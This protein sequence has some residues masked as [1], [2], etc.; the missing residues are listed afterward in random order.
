MAVS[1]SVVLLGTLAHGSTSALAAQTRKL[2]AS[3]GSLNEPNGIAVT[4]TT[5][6]VYVA[7]S[8][9]HRILKFDAFGNQLLGFGADVG[10]PGVD[11]CAAVCEPGTGGTAPGQ[12]T[13]ARFV[14][15]DNS[16]GA[17]SGD[18]YVADTGDNTVSKFD[19]AGN[20]IA[21]WGAGGQLNGSTT[22][23]GAFGAI[24]GIAVDPSTGE[25]LV[26]NTER[27]LFGF[28]QDGTFESEA[29]GGEADVRA[30]GLGIDSEG[31]RLRVTGAGA[32]EKFSAA[33]A[34]LGAVTLE[35]FEFTAVTSAFAVDPNG[36]DLYV[37]TEGQTLDHYAFSGQEEVMQRDGSTCRI[38]ESGCA[39][40][41][42]TPIPF[43]G[44]G[45]G[46]NAESETLYVSNP[47]TGEIFVYTPATIPDVSK[48]AAS[49]VGPTSATLNGSVNPDGLALTGCRFE[50]GKTEAYGQSADCV[51]AAGSIPAD[52]SPHAVSAHVTGLEAGVTY[53]FRLVAED[54][55]GAN[56]SA[57][58][59][60]ATPPRPSIDDARAIELSPEAATLTTRIDPRG[61]DTHYH[62]EYGKTTEYGT[63]APVP[64]EDIGAGEG[65]VVRSQRVS[66]LQEGV[67]YHWRVV[68]ANENG[69]TI[70]TDH[71]F[72]YERAPASL[73]DGRAYEM[74]TPVDKNGALIGSLSLPEVARGG[75]R[76]MSKSIQCFAG[77]E[78]CNGQRKSGTG[79]PYEFER[80]GAGWVATAMSPSATMLPYSNL[81]A[82]EVNSGTA[83]F[84]APP[85]R[86]AADQLYTREPD[87][88]LV[89]VGP[90]TPPG[91]GALGPLGGFAGGMQQAYSPDLSHL[92]WEAP[93]GGFWPS[94]DGTKGPRSVY[95]YAAPGQSEPLLVGVTGGVG[96]NSLVSKCETQLGAATSQA[97]PGTMSADG[98]T[99]YVT[100]FGGEG[101][102]GTGEN[103]TKPVEADELLARVDGEGP[104]AHTV[105]V[106]AR[107][108]SDCSGT[109][110]SAPAAD[111]LFIGASADGAKAFFASTQQLTNQAGEDGQSGDSATDCAATTGRNGCNLYMYDFAN[112]A[113]ERLIDVSAGDTSGGGPRV[114]GVLAVSEDGSHVYFVAQGVLT[115]E[116]NA[117]GEEAQ[118]GADNLY[119]FERD[120]S[121]LTGRVKFIAGLPSSDAGEWTVEVGHPANVTP[122]GRYLVFV[123]H[124]DLTP[125]DT[126]RSGAWQVFRY[127]AHSGQLIRI[128]VGNDGFNN[129]GNG[130][131]P[132]PCNLDLCSEDAELAA[133]WTSSRNPTMSD[134][135]A[136]VFFESPVGLTPQALDDVRLTATS[137]PAYAENVYEWHEGHVYLI[138]DG[139][140]V[141][142]NAG[143]SPRC[144]LAGGTTEEGGSAVCLLGSDASGRDAFFTTTDP[145]TTEDTDTELDYY[146]A[147]ICTEAEP[148]VHSPAPRVSC[149]E[150]ECQGLPLPAP[151]PPVAA[152]VSFAG[153]GNA[154]APQASPSKGATKLVSHAVHGG[155]FA[156]VL[157][158]PSAG[159]VTIGGFGVASLKHGVARA[160]TYRFVVSLT[161][162]ERVTLRRHHRH[163]V[164]LKLKI[165]FAP[166][167]GAP[168]AIT[169]SMTARI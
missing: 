142:Q 157:R 85:E 82:Y 89:R 40:T 93:A 154:T 51:P 129:N 160:G 138:S 80:T 24:A 15:V 36:R 35:S 81:M 123:S 86:S 101:C 19:S 98:R 130:S 103:A 159:K 135:G 102:V 70:G 112:P 150:D 104:E 106:S 118:T 9:N 97:P 128:S 79:S 161:N 122:E 2:T 14:A 114:Q 52:S 165:G 27:Q 12:F 39:P 59:T 46:L 22:G 37:A 134:D 151:P 32:I 148:C 119:V 110:S 155:R 145:L 55:N 60:I 28:A 115:T 48:E 5:G 17:S 116:G 140:D 153:A 131:E 163:K 56:A 152:T 146:D 144:G 73:P 38:G 88:S 137:P 117:Q 34:D 83:F 125:D 107:S 41:D 53:H 77:A 65:D 69:T 111:A 132:S 84:S 1:A 99:V 43:V 127:D 78:A 21:T 120:A 124:G 7:D 68:A 6:D 158:V 92:A 136:Y 126:S 156:L 44:T 143:T 169:I 49:E 57:D 167:A 23:A 63:E 113:A 66:G 71:T 10:G 75:T 147:R 72:V 13:L 18:V 168:S 61:F 166:S 139:K 91:G 20:L 25:L 95:E 100:A 94:I 31:D 30:S 133:G 4:Q 141:G 64:P 58:E 105:V 121:E 74:V 109:C 149:K 8:G 76:V 62:F 54:E 29:Q 50:Y 3:F 96:S 67:T 33:G 47:A 87:G 26:F 162:R 42:S 16:A 90:V 45:I 11:T 164:R 108:P